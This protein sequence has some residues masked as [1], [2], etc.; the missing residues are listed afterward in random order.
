M[1]VIF[2]ASACWC[3]KLRKLQQFAQETLQGNPSA[4][5]TN[6]DASSDGNTVGEC[7][8][9][10]SQLQS[11]ISH[12]IHYVYVY[13]HIFSKYNFAYMCKYQFT[14]TWKADTIR[15]PLKPASKLILK[16]HLSYVQY[17]DLGCDLLAAALKQSAVLHLLLRVNCQCTVL[18]SSHIIIT[19]LHEIAVKVVQ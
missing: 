16:E 13:L 19:F 4:P 1:L 6:G 2:H 18:R 10:W 15:P 17:F 3:C 7:G 8:L 12:F 9:L 11:V 5:A 14:V